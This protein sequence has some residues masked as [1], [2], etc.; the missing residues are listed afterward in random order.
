MSGTSG[1]ISTCLGSIYIYN[2]HR[3]YTAIDGVLE[4]ISARWPEDH[5]LIGNVEKHRSDERKHYLMFRRWFERR[6]TM[7]LA[8]GRTCGHIRIRCRPRCKP[9]PRLL[10]G[11]PGGEL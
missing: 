2:E 7:P 8:V 10:R 4:A 6:G 9:P 5:A 3:G 1:G 11:L